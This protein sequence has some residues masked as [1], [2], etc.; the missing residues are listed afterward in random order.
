VPLSRAT[1]KVVGAT[2]LSVKKISFAFGAAAAPT[3]VLPKPVK[4]LMMPG[5]AAGTWNRE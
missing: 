5:F 3:L 2:P 1:F 4:K